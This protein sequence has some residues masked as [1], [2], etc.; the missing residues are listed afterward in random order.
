MKS[1]ATDDLALARRVAAGDEAALSDFYER[2]ADP[3][4]AFIFHHLE[5]ARADAE[6]LWQDTLLAALRSLPAYRGQSALFTWLCSIARHKLADYYRR[7]GLG[8]EVFSDLPE[9]DLAQLMSAAPLP[10]E[11]LLQR[12]TRLQVVT[13]L[14][15]LPAEYRTALVARYV[16]E[17]SVEAVSRRLG[18]TYK[19][20]ESLLSRA[21]EAFRQALHQAER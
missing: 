1:D 10:E 7:R 18:R 6:E 3:L 20:T 15:T 9:G 16:E 12:A 11:V 13:A 5:S 8:A 4:F 19:A 17:L 2:Y 14:G 21:R